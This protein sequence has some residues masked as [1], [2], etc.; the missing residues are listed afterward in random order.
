MTKK[1]HDK[2][3]LY[4]CFI[5]YFFAILL[6]SPM[7]YS[8][9]LPNEIFRRL[10]IPMPDNIQ[11]FFDEVLRLGQKNQNYNF[12]LEVILEAFRILNSYKRN[13]NLGKLGSSFRIELIKYDDVSG[14]TYY[15]KVCIHIVTHVCANCCRV[16]LPTDN[17]YLK[18]SVC[19][20]VHYCSNMC[21]K[22]HWSIHRRSCEHLKIM[23]QNIQCQEIWN[24]SF[25]LEIL[26]LVTQ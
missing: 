10:A 8:I 24:F 11:F 13:I 1:F 16:R 18:C 7:I 5:F 15:H 4:F 12:S 14:I 20:Q 22:E 3:F 9:Y 2:K 26:K 21:H 23:A 25:P 17:R 19:K 6:F